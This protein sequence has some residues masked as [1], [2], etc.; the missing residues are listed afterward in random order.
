MM[1]LLRSRL[2]EIRF[3]ITSLSKDNNN[4]NLFLKCAFIK[5]LNAHY[6]SIT[7]LLII[8]TDKIM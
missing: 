2:E 7:K 4:N 8:C 1:K 3:T 5:I 6:N